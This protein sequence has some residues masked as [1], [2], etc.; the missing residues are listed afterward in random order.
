MCYTRVPL[1]DLRGPTLH[2]IPRPHPSA[3]P[4]PPRFPIVVAA[5]ALALLAPTLT[6]GKEAAAKAGSAAAAPDSA[7]RGPRRPGDGIAAALGG[8][9]DPADRSAAAQARKLIDAGFENVAIES[10]PAGTRLTFENRRYRH[11]AECLGLLARLRDDSLVA[12][13]RRLDL[14]AAAVSVAGPPQ[15][16][17]FTV[18]YPSDRDFQPAPRGRRL[19]PTSRTLDLVVGPLVAYEL[20]RITEPIQFRFQIEPRLRYS[21]WPGARATAT[22]VIPVYNDFVFNNLHPDVEQLRPGLVTLEQFAWVPRV[23]L[24]SATAGLFADNRYGVSV[25]AARPLAQGR[26]LVDTQADLTGFAA[27]P[28]EGATYSPMRRWSS[29]GGLTWRAPIYDVAVRVRAG[30]F[31]YGDRGAEL[32]FR[33][34]LG[35]LDFALFN[36]RAEGY[37]IKGVR[38]VLPVPPMVRSSH[39]VVR[40]Q[41]IERFPANY[42]TDAT[43]VG[44]FV[45]GV[46][47][48]EDFLRQ[49]SMPALEA[50]RDRYQRALSGSPRRAGSGEADWV[51]FTGMTGFI[52]TPWAGV[53]QDR[54]V[55]LGYNRI[56]KAWAYDARGSH[57]N[58][59]YF[60]ALGVLPHTEIGLR[61]TRVPGLHGFARDDPSSRITTDTD[62]MASFRLMLLTPRPWQPGLAVGVEDIE[63]TRRFHSSYMVVGMP[64]AILHVQ[65]RISLGYAPRVFTATRHVLDGGF[66]A[67]EVSPWRDVAAR[68]EY[69]SE[70]W[71]VGAGVGL[72]FGLRLRIA[73][74]NFESLSVG[75]SWRHEL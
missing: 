59:P 64:S 8:P 10:D 67:F 6:T 16:P 55:E 45:G 12:Y 42:R 35:D 2:V 56:P 38:V 51:S 62:H 49:L 69:D 32:E 70:K 72:G 58:E 65:N 47:S 61:F 57:A 46:A 26:L 41:P 19:S 68:V 48:R 24:A 9:A 33:R 31:L 63:G 43:P 73:A 11:S 28:E 15:A 40:L 52:N 5:A 20:G 4:W 3:A 50:N 36:V 37:N 1:R 39:D 34:T 13:E 75:A 23:A 60:G 17:R 7:R 44:T 27:F 18:R 21:P 66:G 14:V 22:L 30:R 71:N 54:S 29:F 25:G 74:L 53:M